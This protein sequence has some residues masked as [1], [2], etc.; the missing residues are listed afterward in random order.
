MEFAVSGAM[1]VKISQQQSSGELLFDTAQGHLVS[2]QMKQD[3]KLDLT[4]QGEAI[5]QT[6]HQ[7]SRLMKK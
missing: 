2:F 7:E 6:L 3:M 1:K 5:R 4:V